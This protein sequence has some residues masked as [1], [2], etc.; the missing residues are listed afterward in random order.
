MMDLHLPGAD[1]RLDREFMTRAD[2]DRLFAEIERTTPWQQRDVVIGG[3]TIPQPRLT[4]WHGDAGSYTYSGLTLEAEPWTEAIAEVRDMIEASLGVRF[5]SVLA[6][7]YRAG[8][9][10]SIG[11]HS[12]NE[13]ELGR[14]PT[15]ASVS[16]GRER[17]FV[18]APRKGRD[19]RRTVVALPH[20]SLIVMAGS[21]QDNWLHGV[22]KEALPSPAARINLTF[23]NI[24]P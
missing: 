16:L 4:S 9:R 10:D 15:I 17:G 8:R 6:N 14:H 7:L 3:R 24:R 12:D 21:T 13:R 19:G 20:G 1:V 2:A 22:D 11:M 18:L 23:R 5:N